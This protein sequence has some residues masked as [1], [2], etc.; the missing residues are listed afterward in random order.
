[1][2]NRRRGYRPRWGTP[3]PL[4][5]VGITGKQAPQDRYSDPLIAETKDVWQPYYAELLTD[6]DAR[7]I[8]DNM[9]GLLK[10][11]SD[12]EDKKSPVKAR[13]KLDLPHS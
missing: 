8:I 11:L 4:T 9:I 13:R 7:D 5:N 3:L 6:E 12:L 10:L 2:T 1:M